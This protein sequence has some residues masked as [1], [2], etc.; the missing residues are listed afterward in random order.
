M[1]IFDKLRHEQNGYHLADNIFK[2]IFFNEI[3]SI[4]IQILPE[5]VPDCPIDN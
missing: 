5:F 3:S 4:L 1:A 2:Y